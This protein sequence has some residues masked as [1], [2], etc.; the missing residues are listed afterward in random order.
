MEGTAAR[1]GRHG[2]RDFIAGVELCSLRG[3]GGVTFVEQVRSDAW[4]VGSSDC[5]VAASCGVRQGPCRKEPRGTAT[6]WS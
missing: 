5:L 4:W 6:S 1:R 3:I 2:A